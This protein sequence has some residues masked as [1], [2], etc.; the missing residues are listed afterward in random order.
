MSLGKVEQNFA[1]PLWKS[2]PQ[3]GLLIIICNIVKNASKI[4]HSDSKWG[5][6]IRRL[7][8]MYDV[9]ESDNAAH[10]QS[11]VDYTRPPQFLVP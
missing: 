6:L 5:G 9:S 7:Y 11:S 8:N 1:L 4:C 3:A 10:T 2:C